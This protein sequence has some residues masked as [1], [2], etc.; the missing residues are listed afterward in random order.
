[1]TI[2]PDNL[3]QGDQKVRAV[4]TMF[5][6]VAPRY[7]LVNRIMTFRLDVRWRRRTVRELDLPFRD[8]HHVTGSIVRLAEEADKDIS[9]LSLDDM[10]GIEPRI[11]KA[12]FS[13]LTVENSVKSRTSYGGTAPQ[14][15][16]KMARSWIK[17][18]D[19]TLSN[20]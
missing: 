9:E 6:T 7:D 18:L 14:N 11:T 20:S 13:V 8:A 10:Q 3:P 2:D 1:M 17:R 16:R 19:R 12:V 15:V 5:D 4:R